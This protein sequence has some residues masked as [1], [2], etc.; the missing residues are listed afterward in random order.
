PTG[1]Y[2]AYAT[3]PGNVAEDGTPGQYGVYT[4]ELLKAMK[5][6]ALPIEEVFK[7]VR[8]SVVSK[9]NGRQ[10]PWDA[11]SL[12]GAFYFQRGGV[13]NEAP[14]ETV[15]AVRPASPPVPTVREE[16]VQEAGSLAL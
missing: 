15:A 8:Q 1:T 14:R 2:I 7:R 10:S 6:P 13:R 5:E 3:S 16:I 4:G 9:T 11:S 12:T